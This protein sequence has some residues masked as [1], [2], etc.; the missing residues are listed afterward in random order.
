M[1]S[2]LTTLALLVLCAGPALAQGKVKFDRR[3]HL[4]AWEEIS[5]SEFIDLYDL[6][7]FK[8]M[9]GSL[10]SKAELDELVTSWTDERERVTALLETEKAD[11]KR[12]SLFLLERGLAKHEFFSKISWDRL[13]DVSGF[14]VYVQK[15]KKEDPTYAGLVARENVNWMLP[16]RSFFDETWI[17]PQAL[18]RHEDHAI[19]AIFIL[20]SLGDLG[21]YQRVTNAS[22]HYMSWG[23]YDSKLRAAILFEDPF[24]KKISK[25]DKRHAARHIYSHLLLHA[26]YTAGRNL[27]QENWLY[28]GLAS[29]VASLIETKNGK[30]ERQDPPKD[31][32]RKL[33]AATQTPATA[34]THFQRIGELLATPT[35]QH[36]S[37]RAQLE[38]RKAGLDPWKIDMNAI[39][40]CYWRESNL[41]VD[42]LNRGER[43]V[44]FASYLAQ[45][46]R[47]EGGA[48]AFHQAFPG[49]TE[50]A[51]D[52]AFLDHLYQE[53]R[54]LFPQ[55]KLDD[56][57]ITA[58]V[59]QTPI[60][61]EAAG[62][63]AGPP[64]EAG[65]AVKPMRPF[66][67]AD[68]V[69]RELGP[70]ATLALALDLARRG[71]S[72][73]AEARL[74]A[75]LDG[76]TGGMEAAVHARLERERDRMRLWSGLRSEWFARLAEGGKSFRF[77]HEGKTVRAKVLGVEGTTVTVDEN[78]S[79]RTLLDMETLDPLSIAKAMSK[80]L[81][82][83]DGAWTRALPYA[84]TGE[85]RA[86]KMVDETDPAQASFLADL[87]S[88]YPAML[89]HGFPL[90]EL[91]DLSGTAIPR[92][93]ARATEVIERLRVVAHDYA[94][95]AEVAKMR[96]ELREYAK[97]ALEVIFDL[98]GAPQ[99]VKGLW[100]PMTRGRVRL[101][102]DFENPE[103]LED[104]VRDD[105]YKV[106]R[107]KSLFPVEKDPKNEIR[108][109]DGRLVGLG[110][111][112]LR[113][114]LGFG[115]PMQVTW[116]V[117]FEK[118]DEIPEAGVWVAMVGICD[119]GG[120]RF[121]AAHS[122]NDLE[123]V[124]RRVLTAYEESRTPDLHGA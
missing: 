24:E 113:H 62:A 80:D 14:V 81:D 68:L 1:R 76:S 2:L 56:K 36:V 58:I 44:G 83:L 101:S 43:A 4:P 40:L 46:L 23:Q 19:D 91:I 114:K 6:G 52:R 84:L 92:D 106:E 124:D 107:R 12:W 111:T 48:Q 7:R 95:V 61:A 72:D 85:K 47:G 34:L 104:F 25:N 98:E 74:T 89:A 17:K 33:V 8:Q 22:T 9:E 93:P 42:F 70:E 110:K 55:T 75:A 38:A 11:P 59:T 53:H 10:V 119:D 122:H 120:D 37:S 41:L 105:G 29:N 57:A 82:G 109:T 30:L 18:A 45:E 78:K 66:E 108:I 28:E 100:E 88:D 49:P 117:S 96:P 123:V 121:A 63:E 3:K 65:A 69:P 67:P 102:Y 35:Y 15:P 31:T 94:D 97:L 87:K 103:Q 86:A 99:L 77:D 90:G 39:F 32:L 115:A 26:H 79:G 5:F 71:Q 27:I 16:V 60:V 51:L 21:S 50:D 20:S 112:A 64:G 54:R 13:D 118:T 116:K 73:D